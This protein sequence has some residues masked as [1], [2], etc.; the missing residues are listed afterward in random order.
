MTTAGSKPEPGLGRWQVGVVVVAAAIITVVCL[1]STSPR[2]AFY[3]LTLILLVVAGI[4]TLA[5]TIMRLTGNRD[6]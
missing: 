2:T 1:N 6:D 4:V 5:R 3:A